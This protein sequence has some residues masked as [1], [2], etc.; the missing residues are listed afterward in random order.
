MGME[1]DSGSLAATEQFLNRNYTTMQIGNVTDEPIRS[2]ITRDVVGTV[3]LDRLE[4]EFD[5][6]YDADPLGKICVC[7][8]ESGS[9]EENYL[10]EGVTDIFE[11]GEIGILTPP[12]SP[13]SGV[14]HRARY[15]ITMFE[16]REL[17]RVASPGD[18]GSAPVALIGH[19][20]VSPAAGRRLS[21]TIA[22]VQQLVDEYDG[23]VPPLVAATATQYLAATVLETFPN[24]GSADPGV[25]A[26]TDA[27]PATVR[28]AVAY[29]ESHV[30]EDIAAG[31]IAAASYV[32]V[33]ALQL[34]FRRHLDTT[35]MEYLRRMR[36]QGAHEELRTG[37]ADS[38]ATVGSI[39][40]AWGFGHPGRFAARYRRRYGQS[41]GT[42]L[43]R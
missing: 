13:Y 19:R 14:I 34:A 42:T 35:P 40:A 25:G 32:T 31:D 24:T 3:S 39:A 20:P 17:T 26:H 41:P 18:S 38:G 29:M 12:D 23:E 7:G 16:P 9:I 2:R 30:R 15:T 36:L 37:S 28:R 6:R 8:V 22:H 33:R 10:D 11:P 4:L 21:S 43:A 1:F 27:H 5:M